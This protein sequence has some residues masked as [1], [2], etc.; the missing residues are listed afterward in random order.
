MAF[1]EHN[2]ALRTADQGAGRA[3]VLMAGILLATLFATLAIRHLVP[4][5]ALAPVVVTAL[6]AAGAVIAGL[7]LLCRSNR[8]R[9]LW[10]ELAG[11]LTFIGVVISV[12]IEPD[13]L[14]RLFA[15]DQPE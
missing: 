8:F 15:A 2:Q 5:E 4:V 9:I 11:G 13:Q 10:F 3:K 7:A 12:L 14:S 6:F 1:A